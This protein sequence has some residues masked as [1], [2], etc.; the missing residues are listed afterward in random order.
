MPYTVRAGTAHSLSCSLRN[1]FFV[2]GRKEEPSF[3]FLLHKGPQGVHF[4]WD[5][6][7]DQKGD[8]MKWLLL[9][10][11][12]ALAKHRGSPAYSFSCANSCSVCCYLHK[13]SSNNCMR[14]Y[15]PPFISCCTNAWTNVRKIYFALCSLCS[16]VTVHTC[17]LYS[18]MWTLVWTF[19]SNYLS[20]RHL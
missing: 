8:V 3:C 19:L 6:T 17:N 2:A 12:D 9:L 18:L 14:K 4:S 7:E 1:R 10:T 11:Q 20:S 15:F 13:C 5:A 16:K